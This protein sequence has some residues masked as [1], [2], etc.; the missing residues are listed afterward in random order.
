[1]INVV[2]ER[3]LA[4]WVHRA[5][6]CVICALGARTTQTKIA[7]RVRSVADCA[8]AFLQPDGVLVAVH[9]LIMV[10][11]LVSVYSLSSGPHRADFSPVDST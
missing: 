6:L 3:A 11:V 10:S 4:T 1:M 9:V 7:G 8:P 2:N 5:G